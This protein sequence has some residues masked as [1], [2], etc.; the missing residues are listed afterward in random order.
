MKELTTLISHIENNVRKLVGQLNNSK[1]EIEVLRE[2]NIRLRA[3]TDELKQKLLNREIMD[4]TIQLAQSIESSSSSQSSR[5][6]LNE[7]IRE[8]DRCILLLEE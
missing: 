1:K 4:T 8:I 6:K 7:L 2:E 5:K 3:E